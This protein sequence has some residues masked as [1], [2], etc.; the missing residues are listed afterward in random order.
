MEG[1]EDEDDHVHE[2]LMVVG[3]DGDDERE[4]GDREELE[5]RCG[6]VVDER[7]DGARGRRCARGWRRGGA[8]AC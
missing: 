3:V 7:E 5:H 4:D 8:C 1:A 2:H 6:G